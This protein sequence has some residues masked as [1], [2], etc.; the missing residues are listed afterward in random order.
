MLDAYVTSANKAAT[1]DKKIWFNRDARLAV[2][3]T[4]VYKLIFQPWY[5]FYSQMP[6]GEHVTSATFCNS[7]LPVASI[8]SC[9]IELNKELWSSQNVTSH[10]LHQ[11]GRIFQ[12]SCLLT[13]QSNRPGPGL[14]SH[15]G[16]R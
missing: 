3:D 15:R 8:S 13:L 2:G 1:L 5:F 12:F 10:L 14:S 7:T 6:S 4:N 11:L 9:F 16:T